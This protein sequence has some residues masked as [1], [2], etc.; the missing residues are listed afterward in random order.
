ME[1]L[2]VLHK[3]HNPDLCILIQSSKLYINGDFEK[4][5]HLPERRNSLLSSLLARPWFCGT[6]CPFSCP[7]TACRV[8]ESRCIC[9]QVHT[10]C[11]RRSCISI[12]PSPHD[13]ARELGCALHHNSSLIIWNG[14]TCAL[15]S[16]LALGRMWKTAECLQSWII[17][18]ASL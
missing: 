2:R 1:A 5:S 4:F 17:A 10:M 18:S 11:E 9:C 8:S 14:L 12:R 13:L 6:R 3:S 15:N 7:A 16:H